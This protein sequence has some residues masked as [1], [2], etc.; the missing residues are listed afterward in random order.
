MKWRVVTSGGPPIGAA[1]FGDDSGRSLVSR[2]L[3]A[4]P[5]IPERTQPV[6]SMLDNG[7]LKTVPVLRT[8][9]HELMPI[10]DDEGGD[11]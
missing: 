6:F 5:R 7:I 8:N 1:L 10:S 9:F 11:W 4:F 2:P 3:S